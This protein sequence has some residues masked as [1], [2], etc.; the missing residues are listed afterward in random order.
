MVRRWMQLCTRSA[1]IDTNSNKDLPLTCTH[2]FKFSDTVTFVLRLRGSLNR[3]P[4]GFPTLVLE[5][6]ATYLDVPVD[7]VSVVACLDDPS[8]RDVIKFSMCIPKNSL[9]RVVVGAFGKNG[10]VAAYNEIIAN[11]RERVRLAER[12][13]KVQWR[14]RRCQEKGCAIES[15]AR[16]CR[17]RVQHPPACSRNVETRAPRYL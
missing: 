13:A 4:P 10:C 2:S 3:T 1:W 16:C 6:V 12:Q 17:G 14:R 15:T 9:P 5:S 8:V 11:H 7:D